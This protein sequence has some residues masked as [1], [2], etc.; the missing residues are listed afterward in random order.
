MASTQSQLTA[1]GAFQIFSESDAQALTELLSDVFGRDDIA[2]VAADWRGIV[3]FTLSA[4][5]EIDADTVVGFD[6]SS[7]SS[8]P[9]ATLDEVQAAVADGDISEAVDGES[10]DAW[11]EA[12]GID[13]LTLGQCVPPAMP[14]FLG[15][16]PAER[17]AEPTDLISHIAASAA[18]M[19]RIEAL[20]V[21]PGEEIPD[22]VFDA[23][24][25]E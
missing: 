18:I 23:D 10:F 15:G 9:L 11:R 16:D 4:D 21:Q 20:G 13:S 19:A 24:R 5:P 14:E 22:E 25:W 3:Y 12:T 1:N 17:A 2:A 6:A 7:G 8:G